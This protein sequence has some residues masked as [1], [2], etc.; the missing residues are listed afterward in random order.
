MKKAG[1]IFAVLYVLLS[2]ILV[3]GCGQFKDEI[4]DRLGPKDQWCEK[5]FAY[6]KGGKNLEVNCA[7]YYSETGYN[8]SKCRDDV[9]IGP[10]LTIVLTPANG[11]QVKNE[12]VQELFGDINGYIVKNFPKDGKIEYA[13]GEDEQP[14]SIQ[15]NDTVWSAIYTL[16]LGSGSKISIPDCLK[17]DNKNK[18][19]DFTKSSD[20]DLA[21]IM[22]DILVGQ[23]L[24]RLGV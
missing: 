16:K 6:K 10:G 19:I 8:N 20:L 9:E 17:A 13:A 14:K 1:K 7:F 11:V 24:D 4:A 5:T 3:S 15:L 21:S 12:L 22:S 2:G 23:V 18:Y